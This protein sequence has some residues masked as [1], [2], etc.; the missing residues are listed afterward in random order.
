MSHTP[1]KSL[2][3]PHEYFQGVYSKKCDVSI[4]FPPNSRWTKQSFADE[5]DIN[6]I[7]SRYQST[8]VLPVMNEVAPQYL[9]CPA[10]SF[11]EMLDF[12]RGAERLFMELPSALRARFGNDPA[13]FLDF[14]S[15]EQ[16]IP[17][18]RSLGL[19]AKPQ[20]GPSSVAG[21]A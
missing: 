3:N 14:C 2:P 1:N 6:T 7:M 20:E 11:Q 8:G 18:M 5:C 9:E 15:N 13:Y 17:E 10:E 16:N 12:C 4:S 21:D 19:L